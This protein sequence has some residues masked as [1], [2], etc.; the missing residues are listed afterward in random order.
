MARRKGGHKGGKKVYKKDT[1]KYRRYREDNQ[2]Q[3]NVAKKLRKKLKVLRKK[4]PDIKY[5][6]V[7]NSIVKEKKDGVLS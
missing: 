5:K 6:I 3:I 2:R 4:Y 1:G 7:E